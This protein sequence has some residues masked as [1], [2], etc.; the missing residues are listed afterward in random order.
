MPNM[1]YETRNV[2]FY[3][4]ESLPCLVNEWDGF[5]KSQDFREAIL[6]LVDVLRQQK[7]IYPKLSMLADTRT[8][9]IL[10]RE[11]LEWV[12]KEVNPLYVDAGITHEAFL[13]SDD[14]F[15]ASALNRYTQQTTEHGIFT[16]KLFSDIGDAKAWL[17][18]EMADNA[19]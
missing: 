19:D 3:I 11:D 13:L 15:G 1:L 12:T 6:K 5:I 4:D 7:E 16:V 17:S 10:S 18:I 8:L 2:R 9:G 14:A